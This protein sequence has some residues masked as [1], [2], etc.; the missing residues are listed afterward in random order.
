MVIKV[1][2]VKYLID[3]KLHYWLNLK[4]KNFPRENIS[5]ILHNLKVINWKFRGPDTNRKLS[6]VDFSHQIPL[7]E[8]YL[9]FNRYSFR[10]KNHL[11]FTLQRRILPTHEEDVGGCRREEVV[12]GMAEKMERR[13]GRHQIKS[14]PIPKL[15]LELTFH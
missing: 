11:P 6:L 10:N 7:M 9:G 2:Q 15:C 14:L 3:H 8:I 4:K 5:G 1:T 12:T 13:L